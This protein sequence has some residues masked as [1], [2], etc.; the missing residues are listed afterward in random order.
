MNIGDAA[1]ASGVSAKMIRYYEQIGLIP[2]PPRTAAGYRTYAGR[3]VHMLRFIRRARDLGFTVEGIT[4][5]LSLWA[6]RS[7]HSA[8]VKRL[9][10]EQI[11]R[12]DTRIAELTAMRDTLAGLASCCAGDER[13]DCPILADL[14]EAA[15]AAHAPAPRRFGAA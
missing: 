8:E 12:L 10:E 4:E 3:D 15:P 5:L 1:A 6:D 2:P 11:A 9:A 7:R 14:A 13:P